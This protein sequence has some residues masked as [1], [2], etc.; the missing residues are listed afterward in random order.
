MA[1]EIK[2]TEIDLETMRHSFA[3]VLA[4]ATVRLFPEARLGIG[5][6]TKNGFYYEFELPKKLSEDDL[7]KIEDEIRKIIAEEIPFKQL[8]VEREQAFN[9]LV[10][11]GQI[12]KTELLQSI[13]DQQISFYR[14]GKDFIDMCRGPHV[15][16]TGQLGVFKLMHVSDVHWMGDNA[17][18]ILQRIDGIAFATSEQMAEYETSLENIKLRDHRRL[19]KALSLFVEDADEKSSSI[20]WLSKGL[21]LKNVIKKAVN[22]KLIENN[23]TEIE[24]PLETNKVIRTSM[25]DGSYGIFKS[26]RRSYKELPVKFFENG[27]TSKAQKE[28]PSYGLYDV[29]PRNSTEAFIFSAS[30][31]LVTALLAS[32]LLSKEL[33]EKLG[34]TLSA[35]Q[36]CVPDLS[37][38]TLT[39]KEKKILNDNFQLIKATLVESEIDFDMATKKPFVYFSPYISFVA[40]DLHDREWEIG[41]LTIAYNPKG[42]IA[43]TTNSRNNQEKITVIY[44]SIIT[45]YERLIA[46][47]TETMDGAFP[48][49]M[50]P[51]QVDLL[52][53]SEKYNQY[54]SEL[55]NEL[56]KDG[57][58]CSANTTDE[59]IQTKIRRSQLLKTP[60]MLIIGEKEIKT[61][62]IS[63]RN[64]NGQEL[65]LIR[66][67]EFIAKIKSEINTNN[68]Q[69]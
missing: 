56:I 61:N 45:S 46:H 22:D 43:T 67:D 48:L 27:I 40:S 49:W 23:F 62:S 58:R 1:T 14:T 68:I 59:T 25:L 63:L 53:L 44:N 64:R 65:G 39:D 13:P 2:T 7:G 28:E 4:M 16:H 5:P 38:I 29:S 3:H 32:I 19:G 24:T 50:S 52:S 66:I 31:D 11:L 35:I 20:H 6:A 30:H 36:L 57:I 37:S 12:Y 10:Q 17:R 33:Y 34:V 51:T 69:P 15:Q 60:Y 9:T 54:V 18:P 47:L 8:M 55:Y 42:P 26:R 41:K 21:M